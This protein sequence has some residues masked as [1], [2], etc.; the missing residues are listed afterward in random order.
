MECSKGGSE[1]F[2]HL[3]IIHYFCTV[4]GWFVASIVLSGRKVRATQSTILLNGKLLVRAN[5]RNRKKPQV[6]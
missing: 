2:A 1:L 6:P 3:Y 4:A 5:E